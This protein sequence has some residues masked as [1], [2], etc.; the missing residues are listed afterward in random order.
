MDITSLKIGQPYLLLLFTI[1]P[2]PSF[3]M[4][5][6]LSSS[7]FCGGSRVVLQICI[8]F[9]TPEH[10]PSFWGNCRVLFEADSN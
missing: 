6:F 8:T 9:K 1:S 5:P 10:K 3:K 2:Y 7:S 4:D